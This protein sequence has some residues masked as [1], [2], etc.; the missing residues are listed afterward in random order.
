MLPSSNRTP[1]SSP[2]DE[3]STEQGS[4]FLTSRRSSDAQSFLPSTRVQNTQ[5]TNNASNSNFPLPVGAEGQQPTTDGDTKLQSLVS[6]GLGSLL[7]TRGAPSTQAEEPTKVAVT[8]SKEMTFTWMPHRVLRSG[9][10]DYKEGLGDPTKN[11]LSDSE[12]AAHLHW[13]H[14]SQFTKRHQ[15]ARGARHIY[16]FRI[17]DENFVPGTQPTEDQLRY[18]FGP[19]MWG[20]LNVQVR[21][22]LTSCFE[23]HLRRESSRGESIQT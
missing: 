20:G 14:V 16:C 21:Q 8:K 2:P 7:E 15:K 6:F 4:A 13:T 5:T 12:R 17:T 1:E 3:A 9:K 22:H 19:E 11:G 23:R 10:G 18:L